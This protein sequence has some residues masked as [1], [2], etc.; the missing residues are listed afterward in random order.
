MDLLIEFLMRSI[1]AQTLAGLLLLSTAASAEVTVP[2]VDAPT[3]QA[4]I[5]AG[6]Y[7]AFGVGAAELYRTG[8]DDGNDLGIEIEGR[9]GFALKSP[10]EVYLS[11]ARDATSSYGRTSSVWQFEACAQYHVLIRSMVMVYLRGGLGLGISDNFA[12]AG[13][14]EV[15]SG[16]AEL[17]GIGVELRLTPQLS[18]G[19]EP[20]YRHAH[21]SNGGIDVDAHVAGIQLNVAFY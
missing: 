1:S 2:I 6:V 17:V 19:L 18:I 3:T 4:S 9:I 10:W 5:P 7:W 15:D 11:V 20:F 16:L 13:S 8:H 12:G 14:S 21:L